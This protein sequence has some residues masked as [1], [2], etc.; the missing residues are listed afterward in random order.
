MKDFNYWLNY[1]QKEEER[2]LKAAD[3]SRDIS[4]EKSYQKAIKNCREMIELYKTEI[5]A[6]PKKLF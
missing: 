4:E 3:L 1:Y 2:L 6:K 5:A